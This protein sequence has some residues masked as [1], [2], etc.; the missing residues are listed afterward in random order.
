MKYPNGDIFKGQFKD[1][2]MN[3]HGVYKYADGA[4]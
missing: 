3:G 2:K 4:I 1:D